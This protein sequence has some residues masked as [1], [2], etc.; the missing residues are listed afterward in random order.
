MAFI[1][2]KIS[3]TGKQTILKTRIRSKELPCFCKISNAVKPFFK[4]WYI[5]TID[6]TIIMFISQ[7]EARQLMQALRSYL[8]KSKRDVITVDE[9]CAFTGIG[10][11]YVRMHLVSRLLEHELK[12]QCN[13]KGKWSMVNGQ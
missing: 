12:R 2:Q 3:V 4:Q 7:G 6:I 13:A 11:S 1:P 10:K 5:H 8:G 9:F